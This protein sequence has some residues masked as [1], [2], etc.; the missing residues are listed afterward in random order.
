MVTHAVYEI[1]QKGVEFRNKVIHQGYI[2]TREEVAER[3]AHTLT[4]RIFDIVEQ[5]RLREKA[6]RD[7]SLHERKKIS[8]AARRLRETK[9]DFAGARFFSHHTP[10]VSL[11][12]CG[13]ALFRRLSL[14]R[15]V[16]MCLSVDI[17]YRRVR[18]FAIRC[19]RS[20]NQRYRF[21]ALGLQRPDLGSIPC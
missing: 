13:P 12:D 16:P 20:F 19:A 10:H 15:F 11:I 4:E 5:L 2:P 7:Y 17:T 3:Y 18:F 1:D 9:G 14:R 8:D 6:L 21:A